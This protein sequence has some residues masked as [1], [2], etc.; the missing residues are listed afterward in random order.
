MTWDVAVNLE[1]RPGRLAE[2][3]QAAAEAGI[4]LGAVSGTMCGGH[5]VI[6]LLVED[7]PFLAQILEAA[8]FHVEGTRRMELV[9]VD[10]RPGALAEVCRKVAQ[11]GFNVELIYTARANLVAIALDDPDR[12]PSQL[13]RRDSLDEEPRRT[14]RDLRH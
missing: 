1:D 13:E 5:G 2:L 4:N 3:A 6:H 7:G 10:D 11:E 9:A 8:G 12:I 14:G